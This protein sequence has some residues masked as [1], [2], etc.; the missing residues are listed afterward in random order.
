[1]RKPPASG[2]WWTLVT[3]GN[4]PR[5]RLARWT[6]ASETGAVDA[7]DVR[8]LP[9]SET[10]AANARD[11]PASETGSV[12][13]RDMPAG[14]VD[15]HDMRQPPRAQLH[16]NS[17][18]LQVRHNC[19]GHVHGSMSKARRSRCAKIVLFVAHLTRT[20]GANVFL[21]RTRSSEAV[22]SWGS[23]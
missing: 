20:N 10:G 11:M 16:V 12:D 2:V 4:R 3:C 5:A 17:P 8:K 15:A 6:L 9:A 14:A 19:E 13:A 18:A 1:M 23:P 7:R 22:A 21:G